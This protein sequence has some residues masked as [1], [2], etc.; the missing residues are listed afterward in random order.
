MR[1]LALALLLLL[2]AYS[3]AA[4]GI[5]Q[6]PLLV[7]ATPSYFKD[8]ATTGLSIA[9]DITLEAWVKFSG[10]PSDRAGIISMPNASDNGY[11]AYTFELE[12]NGVNYDL[13]LVRSIGGAV[14]VCERASWNPSTGV[15]YHVAVTHNTSSGACTVYIDGVSA[16]T[17]STVGG[18]DATSGK[19]YVGA[20]GDHAVTNLPFNGR[21]SLARVWNTVRSQAQIDANKCN[22]FGTATTNM[23]AEWSLD[24][25]LTDASGNGNT[26]TN[27]NT[28][29]FAVDTPAACASAAGNPYQLWALSLF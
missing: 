11:E 12:K 9:G 17:G 27:V 25:A 7:A 29:A 5:T 24:N 2:P 8:T 26:L 18:A 1:Y 22:V 4:Y 21:I 13:R 16:G 15:W 23:Q 28:V 3:F 14:Q 19:V 10:M 6:S 20:F